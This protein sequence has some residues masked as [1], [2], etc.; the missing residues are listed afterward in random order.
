MCSLITSPLPHIAE[1]GEQASPK[2]ENGGVPSWSAY[3]DGGL[4][5][6]MP[7]HQVVVS[8]RGRQ[9]AMCHIM[10]VTTQNIELY[11]HGKQLGHYI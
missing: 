11:I 2:K 4:G 6:M 10:V 1:P 5:T 3:H 7:C 8:Q 9:D